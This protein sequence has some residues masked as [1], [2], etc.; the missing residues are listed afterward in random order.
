MVLPG[1]G[2][3][4][5]LERSA[6]FDAVL[7]DFLRDPEAFVAAGSPTDAGSDLDGPAEGTAS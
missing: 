4:P 1:A 6:A 5:H 3:L 7:L 2:H